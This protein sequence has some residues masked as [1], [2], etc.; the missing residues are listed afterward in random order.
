[1][2]TIVG[3]VKLPFATKFT[4]QSIVGAV[5]NFVGQYNF[6]SITVAVLLFRLEYG[7]VPQWALSSVNSAVYGGTNVCP[8]V[9]LIYLP[10]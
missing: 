2:S 9:A 5:A 1:M 6:S 8:T 3:G 7:K 4:V 10:L